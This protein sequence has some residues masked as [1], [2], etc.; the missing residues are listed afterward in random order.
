[1]TYPH[2]IFFIILVLPLLGGLINFLAGA[3]SGPW[4]ATAALLLSSILSVFLLKLTVD[5]PS[6]LRFTWLPGIEIG[7]RLDRI[8]VSLIALVSFISMLIHLFSIHYMKDDPGIKRYFAKLG[9]F[10]FSM[11]GVLGADHL[12]LLFVFWELVGFSSYLLI[13]FWYKNEGVPYAARIAFIT[14]RIADAGFLIGII[15]IMVNS[16]TGFISELQSIDQTGWWVGAAGIGLVL[17]AFGKSAQ[18][19]FF[20]WL[21]RAMAGPTPVSALIHAATMVAAGVYLLIR[22]SVIMPPA[23]VSTVAIAGALT[24]FIGA[25]SALAQTDI[26]KVLAYS[27]VSQLGYMVMGVGV[28]ATD[29]ALFH[30]WTHAFFKAGL[31]LSAGAIIHYFHKHF[32]SIDGQDMRN[33][34]NLKSVMPVT[35]FSYLVCMLSLAG[36]PFFSG[37]L[38][39][40]GILLKSLE[41][42]ALAGPW[43]FIVPV[44]GFFTVGL[45]AYYMGKQALVVFYGKNRMETELVK[46]KEDFLT[47]RLPLIILAIG[48]LG[49]FYSFNP[50]V[51]HFQ[52][53][54]FWFGHQ[55]PLS[56]S[57][58]W[59]APAISIPLAVGGLFVAF[60]SY[61][62]E[63]SFTYRDYVARGHYRKWSMHALYLDQFYHESMV[64]AFN[65]ISEIIYGLDRRFIDPVL[66]W[67]GMSFV[68]FSK[69]MDLVDKLIVDKLVE[70]VAYISKLGG[71]FLRLFHGRRVQLHI[72]W[73]VLG[74]ILILLWINN[75]M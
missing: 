41:W 57:M 53:L 39:K 47:V 33:M 31:F 63:R 61:R 22:T 44:L 51:H 1:M 60:R 13:G 3:R 38:S 62:P 36:L 54:D 34:G 71:D 8:S 32:H 4:I 46:D 49:L 5:L 55:I 35:Q 16:G 21:P 67:L 58:G 6:V 27:T 14:N 48:S 12:L 65:M 72:F 64:K 11:L 26:K 52:I 10:T 74:T 50:F 40:D 24:A 15:L 73:A 20:T 42:S 59:L 66:N 37:F 9:F 43:A 19:P 45:T 30:L 7:W 23:L 28:G 2:I 18:V 69:L 25:F 68:V 70:F 29:M 56:F 17:G 75:F